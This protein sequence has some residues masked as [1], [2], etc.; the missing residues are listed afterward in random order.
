MKGSILR[1]LLAP[2][3]AVQLLTG[4][5]SFLDNPLIGS[6]RL[7]RRGLHV[8]RVRTAS[9]LAERRRARLE[10]A[11]DRADR[12]A[13]KRD[14]YVEKRDFLPPDQFARMRDQLLAWRGPA[15]EM[16]QGDTITRRYAVDPELLDAVPAMAAFTQDSSWR[17]LARYVASFDI[18]PLLYVQT[19]LTQRRAAPADPQ[20]NLHADTFH[21]S[22]KAWLFL[23]DV[24]SEDGPLTYVPGSH[25][26]TP[27]RL[28]WERERSLRVRDDGDYLSARG[29]FRIE[30]AELAQLSLPEPTAFTVPANTLVIADTFGFHARAHSSR[31]S[32]RIELF[33]Y[34]RRNPFL[35]ITGMDLWSIRGLA[36]RRIPLLWLTHDIYRHWIGQPWAKAGRKRPA[37]E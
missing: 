11:V 15:R 6:D 14:G 17:A 18:E 37:D 13:F 12:E 25:R 27:E 5:R 7:N 20:T 2:W 34:S 29:S 26:L 19:I 1:P 36:E 4:A 22:M 9:A 35:P 24:R 3:W 23:E 16:V 10:D 32:T 8:W 28:A 30:R 31:P 33:A 21:P